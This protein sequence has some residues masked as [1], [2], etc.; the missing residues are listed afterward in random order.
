MTHP[1]RVYS[2][3]QLLDFVWGRNVYV[4]ERTVDVHILRLRKS[5]KSDSS[6]HIQT[7]RGQD[8]DFQIKE[9]NNFYTILDIMLT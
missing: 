9:N 8:I 6:K 1:D 5:L 4:E 7:V 2:R 3:S